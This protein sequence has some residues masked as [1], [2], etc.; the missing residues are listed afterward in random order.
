MTSLKQINSSTGTTM[1]TIATTTTG[2][3]YV[4]NPRMTAR[5]VNVHY[6]DKHA[7]RDVTIDIAEQE[8]IVLLPPRGW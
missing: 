6:G 1:E 3:V 7:I 5:N 4:D 8:V 2:N